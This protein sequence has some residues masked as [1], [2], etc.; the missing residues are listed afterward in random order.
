LDRFR[1]GLA[2]GGRFGG[3]V[4]GQLVGMAGFSRHDAARM[5][6]RGVLVGMY[7][8]ESDRGTGVADEIANAVVA[9]ARTR[10]ELL[11]LSVAS[12][13]DRAVRFYERMG[14]KT[15][16]TEPRALKIDDRYVDEFLMVRFL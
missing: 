5:R 15:Y 2:R 1:D 4:N 11:Q 16:A 7:V 10:V 8:R 9:Y 3:F 13:N 12:T 6:H 14:F